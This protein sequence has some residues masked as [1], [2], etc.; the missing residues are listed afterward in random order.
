MTIKISYAAL[1]FQ[2][3]ALQLPAAEFL[4]FGTLPEGW[5]PAGKNTKF[6]EKLKEYFPDPLSQG[7]I[8]LNSRLRY[9]YLDQDRFDT[10]NALT[11]RTRLGY[12]TPKY[13]GVYGLAEFEGTWAIT[14]GDFDAF[15]PPAAGTPGLIP[16]PRNTQL[17][18]LFLG[19]KAYNS[20]LRIG[21]QG[22]NLDNQR[23]VGTVAWRQNDQTFDTLRA[24]TNII[25][26]L[27]L[28]YAYV[29]E[30][31]RIF[32]DEAPASALRAFDSRS[33]LVNAAYTGLEN[34]SFHGYYYYLEFPN[35]A[36]FSSTTYGGFVKGTVPL[37]E[38][39]AA[40][41]RAE[42]AS[43]QDNDGS[44]PGTDLSELYVHLIAGL[45][46]EGY[47]LGLGYERLGGNGSAAFQTPLATLHKFNGW[48]DVFLVTPPDGLEDFYVYGT[49][50]VPFGV[51]LFGAAHYFTAEDRT[52]T[53]G[54]ELDI[55]AKRKITENISVLSKI[56]IYEGNGSFPV[57]GA[58]SDD[59]V[60]F[61]IQVDFN[62]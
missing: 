58:L 7:K 62:L 22:I 6:G 27:Y 42:I 19:W 18:R 9:E 15:P 4:D 31:L 2:L 61:W 41:Y 35:A 44:P 30:V 55:G 29:E 59:R 38:G 53:Y 33:H 48:A 10:A 11:W 1:F 20:H 26:D 43:Q 51:N 12:E 47:T 56:A 5:T 3:V 50:K 34:I 45:K 60:R 14:S 21:R 28:S 52:D 40:T 54:Y 24:E 37:S 16:D 17:N 23:F 39:F 25:K 8:I 13:F 57:D 32:G 49:A 46:Y 36:A